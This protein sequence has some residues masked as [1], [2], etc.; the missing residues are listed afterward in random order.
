MTFDE[1][2]LCHQDLGC[3]IPGDDG[4]WGRGTR[5]AINLNWQDVRE[6]V[7]WLSGKAG[8]E[9]RL[10]SEAEWEYVTRAGTTT[11]FHFGWTISADQANYNGYFVYGEGCGGI[12]LDGI[13]VERHSDRGKT[14]PVGSFG[15]NDFG[16]YDVHGNVWE[17]VQDCWNSGYDGG[18]TDGSAWESGQCGRRVLR[19]GAWISVPRD[20]RAASRGRM[21][22]GTRSYGFRVAR[23]LVP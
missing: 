10:L 18:P 12:V 22:I 16:L 6:Y 21:T 23:T 20:L 11:P 3:G 8:R 1:W 14:V 17:W 4:G 5:P 15:A 19:G 9:Y 13:G 2:D 7:R